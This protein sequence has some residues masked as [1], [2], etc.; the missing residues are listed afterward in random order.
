MP[1]KRQRGI[2]KRLTIHQDTLVEKFATMASSRE[3]ESPRTV[4]GNS[5]RTSSR[6]SSSRRATPDANE[7]SNGSN[8]SSGSSSV[9]QK[10]G[11][12]GRRGGSKGSRRRVNGG[13]GVEDP[14][15]FGDKGEMSDEDALLELEDAART[16][17]GAAWVAARETAGFV[18]A[19]ASGAFLGAFPRE[20]GDYERGD[21]TSASPARGGTGAPSQSRRP[22]GRQPSRGESE[23][24]AKEMRERASG[25]SRAATGFA[26]S[27]VNRAGMAVVSSAANGVL[28]AAEAAADWAGGGTLAREHVLLFIAVFCL[29]F[30]RGIGASVALLVVIRAGRIS[31]ERLLAEGFRREHVRRMARGGVG[32]SGAAAGPVGAGSAPSQTGGIPP[33]RRRRSPA[34]K[35][36]SAGAS[37]RRATAGAGQATRRPTASQKEGTKKARR[38]RPKPVPKKRERG[39]RKPLWDESDDESNKGCVVM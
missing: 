6:A 39:K 28:R 3:G 37:E 36:T 20:Y 14:L 15:D 38:G 9:Y 10:P 21:G 7:G 25:V 22:K 24:R 2:L 11:G 13:G 31:V 29:V 23:R 5:N 16:V 12:S 17:G 8:G 19:A 1:H 4:T 33:T 27:S 30:K 26:Q 35:T 18:T 32:V 34:G